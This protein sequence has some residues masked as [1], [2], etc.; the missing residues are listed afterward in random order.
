MAVRVV[1][2]AAGTENAI[3]DQ[4]LQCLRFAEHRRYMLVAI[5]RDG[6]GASTGWHDAQ[7]MIAAGTADRIVY[8]SSSVT[9]P[10]L[11]SVTSAWSAVNRPADLRPRPVRRDGAA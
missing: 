2:Y 7:T 3:N 6:P 1:I 4:L 10:Y 8:A 5:A 11:E 9:P